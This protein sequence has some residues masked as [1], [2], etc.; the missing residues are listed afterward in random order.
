M[1]RAFLF[2]QTADRGKLLDVGGRVLK[3]RQACSK[4]T[5]YFLYGVTLLQAVLGILWAVKQFGQ[6]QHWQETAEYLQ[7]SRS[8]APDE[9][10]A[11]LYPALLRVCTGLEQM[12]GIPCYIPVYLL[13]LVI[14][15]IGAYVFLR[16]VLQCPKGRA[17]WG[18][19]Y[20]LSFPLL[21]QFHL[22]VRPESLAISGILGLTALWWHPGEWKMRHSF[23]VG[24]LSC[25]LI[26]LQP[27]LVWA[28]CFLGI[29]AILY[30]C[31]K[32]EED[33]REAWK[34]RSRKKAGI[35]FLILVISCL[36]GTFANRLVQT[37]GS[38]GRIQKTF[39][40]A[41]FQRVVTDYFSRSYALWD[42]QVRTTYTIEEAMECAK[43][44][45]NMMYV[46]GPALERDWGKQQANA[47]YRDMTLSCLRVRTKDVLGRISQDLLD[48]VFMPFSLWWQR[49]GTRASVTGW[50]YHNFRACAPALS[51]FYLYLSCTALLPLCIAGVVKNRKNSRYGA[52][53]LCFALLVLL[54]TV[55][56]VLGTGNSVDYGKLLWVICLYCILAV[57]AGCSDKL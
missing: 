4:L 17:V 39:W 11:L 36:T 42:E 38:G 13:Q 6:L 18:M 10:R 47:S 33:L 46:V 50:N 12:A 54:Q 24:I 27:D 55:C 22:S 9:Y 2:W 5:A 41:A 51:R 45:D 48:S 40:A 37:P 34:G 31:F 14:A 52:G 20:V 26:W 7:L 32:K 1:V 56:Q 29:T 21:L 35:L 8:F 19:A 44:S 30:R 3:V 43:R 57:C 15:G 23:G 25:L 53:L 16:A 28:V 49:G